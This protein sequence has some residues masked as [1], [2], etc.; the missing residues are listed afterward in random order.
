MWVLTRF[1]N[2]I[3]MPYLIIVLI[4]NVNYRKEMEIN[5]IKNDRSFDDFDESELLQ[6]HFVHLPY[7][8]VSRNGKQKKKKKTQRPI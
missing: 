1:I 5:I 2:S 4:L 6:A 7:R 8:L 3:I